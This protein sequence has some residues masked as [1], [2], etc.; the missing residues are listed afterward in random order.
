ME[1]GLREHGR[2]GRA[3]AGDVRGL[4]CDLAH[5]L[6]AHVLEAIL[7]LDFFGDGDAVFGHDRCAEALLDHD[8]AAL[9]DRA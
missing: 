3:V 7:E 9:A 5:H 8:V 2:G 4:G 1:D 6:R